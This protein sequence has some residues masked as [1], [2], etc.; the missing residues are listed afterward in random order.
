MCPSEKLS[1]SW[2]E[3]GFCAWSS[4]EWLSAESGA[5]LHTLL[6][7]WSWWWT[8]RSQTSLSVQILHLMLFTCCSVN[9]LLINL[10]S[11]TQDG[12][13]LWSDGSVYGYTNWCSGEPS[14][15]SEHC[16]EINWT[17]EWF[18]L[19]LVAETPTGTFKCLFVKGLK[20]VFISVCTWQRDHHW[21]KHDFFYSTANR[22][23]ND[24]RC[25]TRM[26]YLCA[27]RRVPC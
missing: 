26:G 11:S 27:K 4:G 17:C 14:G 25:S 10:I 2:R 1:E 18:V 21:S 16:L 19:L 3:S 6:D 24:Q 7:W 13:W 12:Q 22:C 9:R 20:L 8:S 23:W 5:G 15:G